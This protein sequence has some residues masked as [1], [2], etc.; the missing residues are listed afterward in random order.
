VLSLFGLPLFAILLWNSDISHK[1]GLVRWKGREYSVANNA[2]VEG[3]EAG[4]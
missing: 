4:P 2:E 3:S 1:N